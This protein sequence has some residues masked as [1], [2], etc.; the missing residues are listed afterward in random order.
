MTNRKPIIGPAFAS[1]FRDD[2]GRASAYASE[3]RYYR[4][5]GFSRIARE[6]DAIANRL[7]AD[8][9]KPDDADRLF[10]AMEQADSL[11]TAWA[12]R[13]LRH[14]Y[15]WF[16]L[17]DWSG[18]GSVGFWIE[19]DSAL[20]D[21]DLRLDAGDSVPTGFSGIAAFV[22]DHGNVTLQSFSR[23]RMT[24]ELFSVV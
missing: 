5:R 17:A 10:D 2:S 7:N 23:G 24:R 21:A 22:T 6:L 4:P 16:G 8:R 14:D 19:T 18:D 11:L 9:A 20:E 1:D 15:V 12:R 13:I 3:L